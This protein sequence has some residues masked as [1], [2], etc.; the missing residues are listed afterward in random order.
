MV[1][2]EMLYG[3]DS[4]GRAYC[5]CVCDC[6]NECIKEAY[7]LKTARTPPSCGCLKS[8]N[9]ETVNARLRK[10]YTGMKFGRATVLEMIYEKCST[11]KAVCACECGTIFTAHA[12]DLANGHTQSCGCLQSQETSI[13]NTK[14][15]R[16]IVSA[17]GVEF[18]S[19]AMKREVKPGRYVWLWNCRCGCCGEE[20]VALP[21]KVLNGHITSCG[22]AKTSSGER[23]ISSVLSELGIQYIREYRFE[24]CRNEQPLRFDFYLPDFHSAI[25]YQGEQHYKPV[26]MWGGDDGYTKRMQND[27]IKRNYCHN[28]NIS[29]LEV[30]YYLSS[31]EI[32][33]KIIKHCESVETVTPAIAI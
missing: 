3:Y 12:P 23:L 31:D 22:C 8:A 20:F 28:N 25:E 9:R 24:D 18:L 27:Q 7:G 32:K 5:R 11:T 33:D 29:L 4:R 15:F 19:P 10:D 1:V 6:G 26:A 2:V 21:A 13:A 16:G 30:P 14:D 17:H